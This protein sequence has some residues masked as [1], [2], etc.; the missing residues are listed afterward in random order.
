MFFS[1]AHRPIGM[2]GKKDREGGLD[3]AG[4]PEPG[5]S[6]MQGVFRKRAASARDGSGAQRMFAVV[7]ILVVLAIVA[8]NLHAPAEPTLLQRLLASLLIALCAAPSLMWAARRPWRHSVM[9]YVGVLY[10]SCFA[11]PVFVRT[12]FFGSWRSLPLIE[13]AALDDA[14]MLAIAGWGALL[15]GYFAIAGGKPWT[16]LPTVRVLP[17]DDP[18][19]AKTVAVVVGFAAAPFFYLDKAAVAARYAGETLLPDAV[20]FPVTLAGQFVLFA[21]LVCFHLHLRG[22]LGVAGRL[23]LAALV[24]YYTV[25]GFSTGML[26]H[27]VKA[28][29]ALFVA[30]AV[31]SPRPTWR[32]IAC[33]VA[34]AAAFV[35]VLIPTRL[36]YRQLVWAY[37]EGPY[38]ALPVS[39]HQFLLADGEDQTLTTPAYDATLRG[40]TLTLAH[41]DPDVCRRQPALRIGV[42]IDPIDANDLPERRRHRGFGTLGTSFD[43]GR[44]EDGRCIA[45]VHLPDYRKVAVRIQLYWLTK[46]V[47]REHLAPAPQAHLALV[48]KTTVFAKTMA[49]TFDRI[50][51]VQ[52]VHLTPR[53]LDYLLPLA[54]L[55]MH[56]PDPLPF[57][58]G[59]TFLPILY[60]LVPR[61]IFADKPVDVW[62][63]STRYG[64]RSATAWNNFKVHQL[65]EFYVNFGVAGVL[66]GMFVLGL[67]C[68]SLHELFHQPGAGAATLAAGT[69]MLVVLALEMESVLSVS[70]GFLIWY[71]IALVVLALV[72][73]AGWRLR[74]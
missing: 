71:A 12:D 27:G 68:R 10:A 1:F 16:A 5:A 69:H 4:S 7:A 56:T 63:I 55:T 25:L 60:K 13:A 29:F 59:E 48:E 44:V 23:Y 2:A 52:R 43:D 35:F 62:D 9:P 21:A 72:V 26:N 20:A 6:F 53:R 39:T 66:L 46:A 61:A 57:L 45:T 33:G 34:A 18:K 70:L 50:D 15:A 28:V 31:V 47:Q 40:R 51:G 14:L 17:S 65:G 30:Y 8:L 38:V 36:E 49:G 11:A 42:L 22:Q 24:A 3:D 19:L 67:L 37:G 32:G 73:R 74:G 41:S 58:Y 64:F 54:W